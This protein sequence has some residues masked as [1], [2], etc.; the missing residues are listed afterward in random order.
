[1]RKYFDFAWNPIMCSPFIL[2]ILVKQ[3]GALK[4]EW[5]LACVVRIVNFEI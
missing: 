1:M 5:S 3:L 4:N 2:W